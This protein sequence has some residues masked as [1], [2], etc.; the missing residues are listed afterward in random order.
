M[1]SDSVVYFIWYKI[2]CLPNTVFIILT[3]FGCI[4]F[5]FVALQ[6]LEKWTSLYIFFKNT[7]QREVNFCL[8]Y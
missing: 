6:V 3:T 4:L 1:I 2:V 8:F 7:E 5:Y